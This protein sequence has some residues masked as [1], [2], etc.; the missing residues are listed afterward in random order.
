MH[1][2]LKNDDGAHDEKDRERCDTEEQRYP[3]AP[4][5]G[6]S[7]GLDSLGGTCR[8]VAVSL[9]GVAD[10]VLLRDRVVQQP[11]QLAS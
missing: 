8:R 10:P 6:P 9:Q 3:N 7:I 4:A 11:L 5:R 2:V 1:T